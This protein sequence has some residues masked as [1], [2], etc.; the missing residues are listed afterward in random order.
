M[1]FIYFGV[2]CIFRILFNTETPLPY[3]IH[4]L[5]KKIKSFLQK[6]F[7]N[8][9]I[10]LHKLKIIGSTAAQAWGAGAAAPRKKSLFAVHSQRIV[11]PPFA[12][13]ERMIKIRALRTAV[14][15]A[16]AYLALRVVYKLYAHL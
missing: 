1:Y 3:I 15:L 12:Y 11:K 5:R 10:R 4:V 9:T 16:F 2:P 7:S 8:V 14:Y 6:N 13:I